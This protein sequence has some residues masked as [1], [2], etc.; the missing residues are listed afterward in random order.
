M[1]N[2]LSCCS[3]S[4]IL[5][6][7]G[8]LRY[9]SGGNYTIPTVVRAPAAWAASL[10]AEHKQRLEAYFHAVPGIKNRGG[11]HPPNAKGLNEG[12]HPRNN[13]RALLRA[14]CCLATSAQ[15]PEG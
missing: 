12:R 14:C 7:M 10:G 8:M 1:N 2:G 6:N 4:P 9:T 13:P 3:P 11:E 5:H 15:L